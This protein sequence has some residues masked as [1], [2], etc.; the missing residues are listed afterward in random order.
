MDCSEVRF[1]QHAFQR[2]FERELS[3][4]AVETA[5]NHGEV[6]VSYDDDQPLPSYLILWFDDGA[7]V[8]TVIAR[9]DENG[10]CIVI[11]VYRPTSDLWNDDFR[12]RR[13]Q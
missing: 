3:P 1:S 7:P 11:T 10:L 13:Q 8:H 2:M 4:E 12:T 9:N 6:I 5:I